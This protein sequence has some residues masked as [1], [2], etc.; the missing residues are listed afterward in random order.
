M[1][2]LLPTERGVFLT[3]SGMCSSLRPR[4]SS[5]VGELRVT[6]GVGL[7]VWIVLLA[8][9]VRRD[10]LDTQLTF[11]ELVVEFASALRAMTFGVVLAWVAIWV[12]GGSC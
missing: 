3:I 6:W 9:V 7:E 12:H 2:A 1:A 10:G 5:I 4:A 8:S 11:H